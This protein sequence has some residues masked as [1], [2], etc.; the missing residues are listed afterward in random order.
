MASWSNQE[1]Y[2]QYEEFSIENEDQKYRLFVDGYSGDAGDSLTF[3]NNQMFSTFDSDNDVHSSNCAAGDSVGWWYK[4]CYRVLLTG[5]YRYTG[6]T[7]PDWR[8][9][10]WYEHTGKAES[11]KFAEMKVRRH[12]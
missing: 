9:I 11:L 12:E 4:N 8:G 1:I 6:E 7:F 10:I 3:H 5:P 2:A